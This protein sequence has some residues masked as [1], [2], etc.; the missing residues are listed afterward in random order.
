ME[1]R[2]PDDTPEPRAAF[3]SSESPLSIGTVFPKALERFQQNLVPL[4]LA[5]I[6]FM[7]AGL[8]AS[9]L[10]LIPVLG[11]FLFQFIQAFLLL[12]LWKVVLAAID[13][14]AVSVGQLLSQ[15]R[16]WFKGGLANLAFIF[17]AGA[18]SLLLF[19]PGLLIVALFGLWFPLVVDRGLPPFAAL[20]ESYA[21]V[22]PRLLTWFLLVLIVCGLCFLGI[23]CLLVGVI[24]ASA[25]G[26]VL[27]GTAYR[28]VSPRTGAPLS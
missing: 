19:I 27:L 4:C 2:S 20:G 15:S 3:P 8:V 17:T 13:G 9:L 14:E 23:L 11:F 24:P 12:G 26:M 18:F 1:Q 28:Q 25:L 10:N 7:I 16:F 6:V 22:K 21:L 5:V